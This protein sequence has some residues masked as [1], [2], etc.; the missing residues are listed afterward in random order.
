[1]P[2]VPDENK[3][4]TYSAEDINEFHFYHASKIFPQIS[5][6][7]NFCQRFLHLFAVQLAPE[8]GVHETDPHIL[9]IEWTKAILNTGINEGSLRVFGIYADLL[10]LLADAIGYSALKVS[11]VL[12]YTAPGYI[13]TGKFT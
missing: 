2:A 13:T 3:R 8:K 12:S 6:K 4:P 7:A 11:D 10:K 1:M 5:F 9:S